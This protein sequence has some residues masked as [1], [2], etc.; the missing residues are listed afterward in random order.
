MLGAGLTQGSLRGPDRRLKR[1]IVLCLCPGA[2]LARQGL[3]GDLD[4]GLEGIKVLFCGNLAYPSPKRQE[5]SVPSLLYAQSVVHLRY[6]V[7][8]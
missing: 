8:P 3:G 7:F 5:L 2:D 6:L 1:T 4:Q